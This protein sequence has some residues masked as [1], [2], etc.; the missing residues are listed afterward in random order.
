MAHLSLSNNVMVLQHLSKCT[1]LHRVRSFKHLRFYGFKCTRCSFQMAA[2]GKEMQLAHIFAHLNFLQR[3]QFLTLYSIKMRV[4]FL[5]SSRQDGTLQVLQ[6][7][8]NM[9]C[10]V[11]V[12]ES[13]VG[14]K[15]FLLLERV[16]CSECYIPVEKLRGITWSRTAWFFEHH[17]CALFWIKHLR[18][19]TV[20][21][22]KLMLK[23]IGLSLKCHQ[24][25]YWFCCKVLYYNTAP[26]L[27]D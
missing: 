13:A 20:V 9:C 19:W 10:L 11:H 1:A 21:S 26:T 14:L 8:C 27:C 16:G 18:K 25:L 23:S 4:V 6:L 2:S 5:C 7:S 15:R 17:P 24:T 22:K 3:L 12:W